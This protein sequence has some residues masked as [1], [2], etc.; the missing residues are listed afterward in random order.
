MPFIQNSQT[1]INKKLK[2]LEKVDKREEIRGIL[3]RNDK[4]ISWLKNKMSNKVDVYYLLSDKSTNFDISI[5]EEIVSVFRKEGLIATESDR[6]EKLTKQLMTVNGLIGHSLQLINGSV[7]DFVADKVIDYKE[8]KRLLEIIRL[9]EK[10][11][12]AEL[13]K[14]LQIIER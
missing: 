13:E 14:V 2:G 3:F 8:K 1:T 9:V 11:F 10:E 6:C 5:Y 12:D 4:N 7:S